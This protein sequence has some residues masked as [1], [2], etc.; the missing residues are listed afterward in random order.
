MLPFAD[1]IQHASV[2]RVFYCVSLRSVEECGH[3]DRS[4]TRTWSSLSP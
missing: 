3:P 2:Y 4:K 1:M